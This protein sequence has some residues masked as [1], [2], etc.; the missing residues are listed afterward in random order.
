MGEVFSS[1]G[2][3]SEARDERLPLGEVPYPL[4]KDSSRF[5]HC[6][7]TSVWVNSLDLGRAGELNSFARGDIL[8]V[9]GGVAALAGAEIARAF[10]FS[11]AEGSCSSGVGFP[12]QSG[13][14]FRFGFRLTDL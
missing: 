8:L 5:S 3:T 9:T 12:L 13:L 10:F 6:L 1:A 7:S 14:E 11:D 2:K 4:D